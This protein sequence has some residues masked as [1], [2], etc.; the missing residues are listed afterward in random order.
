[1]AGQEDKSEKVYKTQEAYD[2]WK[3]GED[4]EQWLEADIKN[5]KARWY[6]DEQGKEK[7]RIA[8]E[9][10]KAKGI[11][12]EKNAVAGGKKSRKVKKSKRKHTKKSKT[13][14]RRS[15]KIVGGDIRWTNNKKMQDETKKKVEEINVFNS[16]DL[17]YVVLE[18]K[19]DHLDKALLARNTITCTYK[20][21]PQ[22]VKK[23][24]EVV[25]DQLT[26]TD[27][28]RS[29]HKYQSEYA[30]KFWEDIQAG[31]IIVQGFNYQWYKPSQDAW[32]S[33]DVVYR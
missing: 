1:M 12:D 16:T 18:K 6:I 22:I 21:K 10:S 27:F 20:L 29:L 3:D 11:E 13:K 9:E 5:E 8:V 32:K 24:G 26:K 31:D 14:K 28:L 23:G 25:V 33:E 7:F 19:V 2:A 17:Y 4:Y 15:Q 30:E